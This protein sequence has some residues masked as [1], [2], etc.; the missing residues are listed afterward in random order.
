MDRKLFTATAKTSPCESVPFADEIIGM[1]TYILRSLG[2]NDETVPLHL[3]GR[4]GPGGNFL[5]EEHTAENFGRT[6]W[7]PTSPPHSVVSKCPVT[8]PPHHLNL[9]QRGAVSVPV[10]FN[11]RA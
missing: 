2:F 7:L 6:F 9:N 11:Q 5:M 3:M 4:V 10:S 1:I 8:Q